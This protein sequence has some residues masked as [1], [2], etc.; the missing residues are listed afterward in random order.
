MYLFGSSPLYRTHS[1]AGSEVDPDADD[2]LSPES[3]AER[4]RLRR[5]A[6]NARER[7]VSLPCYHVWRRVLTFTLFRSLAGDDEDD[8]NMSPETKAERERLRRQANN[9][10]ER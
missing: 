2:N 4:E 6:N 8:A 9:N 3:K 1:E 7:W 10:R 5:Q